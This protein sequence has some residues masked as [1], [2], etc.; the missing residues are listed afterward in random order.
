MTTAIAEDRAGLPASALAT[1]Q[2]ALDLYRGDYVEGIHSSWLV[3]P[4]LR[5]RSLALNGFCRLA[6]LTSAQGEPEQAARW[7]IRARSIDPL[8]QRAARLFIAALDAGGHRAG[9]TDA[10]DELRTAL[11][12]NALTLDRETT[13]LLDRLAVN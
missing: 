5:L 10:A 12:A 6:E 2:Q 7:A 8:D 13:R 1:Y 11:S 9:A 4:R 3:L